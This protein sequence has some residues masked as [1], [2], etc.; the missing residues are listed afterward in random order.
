[1]MKLNK[2]NLTQLA[3]EVKIPTYAIA[4]T[5]PGHRPISASAVSTARIRRITPM[6]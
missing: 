2:H 5:P 3:P 4:D 6:R 1:M